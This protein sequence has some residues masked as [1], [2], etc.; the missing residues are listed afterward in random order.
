MIVDPDFLDHWRT[1]MVADVIGD[2]MAPVYILRLWAHCQER[3]SDSFSMPSA[4]LKAQCKCPAP[5]DVFERALIEAGFITRD[6][7]RITV[8]GWAKKNASLIAAWENGA[9]GGRPRNNPDETHGKPMGNPAVT[10]REPM[11]NPRV[12]DKIREDKSREESST[13]LRSVEGAKRATRKCPESFSITQ[14]LEQWAAENA[15]SVDI[16]RE[17]EKFRDYTFKTAHSDWGGA[18]R[19]WIRRAS[20]SIPRARASPPASETAYQRSM[21]ERV[22]SICPSIAAKPPSHSETF[23]VT[24]KTLDRADIREADADLRSGVPL[25]LGRS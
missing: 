13:S 6:G 3:K 2:P 21:R 22:A 16:K 4:G 1:G 14:D 12:T 15:P 18:W 7:D 19:N 17:T 11:A 9:R 5:A 10:Q 23:D 8:T 24:A 20:E 25:S